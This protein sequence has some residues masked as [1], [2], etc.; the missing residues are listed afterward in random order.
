MCHIMAAKLS[1]IKC[2]R[3]ASRRYSTLDRE[4]WGQFEACETTAGIQR[5]QWQT[6]HMNLL[7]LD[8]LTV[9]IHRTVEKHIVLQVFYLRLC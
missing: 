5:I 7:V 3:C 8:Q 1:H 2:V 6:Y 4:I 9:D